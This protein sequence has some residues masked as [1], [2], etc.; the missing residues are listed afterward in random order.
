MFSL[1]RVNQCL[2][3]NSISGASTIFSCKI[4]NLSIY[5][6]KTWLLFSICSSKVHFLIKYLYLMLRY[7]ER[8]FYE[9]IC[10]KLSSWRVSYLWK[11]IRK[12]SH[13]KLW[14]IFMQVELKKHG[15]RI[16]SNV[17]SM[18]KL[19]IIPSKL[20]LL[21]YQNSYLVASTNQKG[22][23]VNNQWFVLIFRVM[24]GGNWKS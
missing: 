13:H 20:L 3:L 18:V 19:Q 6:C 7:T 12:Q 1:F 5:S 8:S 21:K 9:E 17:N 14:D 23:L 15:F 2:T 16:R 24:C 22:D 4:I 10:D 11:D